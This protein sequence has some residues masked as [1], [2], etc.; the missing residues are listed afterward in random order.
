MPTIYALS[1][2]KGYEFRD[3]VL[4]RKAYR[5]KSKS[6][7]WQYRAERRIELV[8]NNGT[9][10]YMLTSSGKRKFYSLKQIKND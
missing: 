1:G 7:K 3:N 9:M 10:G 5:T 4:F 8:S 6:C 2:F